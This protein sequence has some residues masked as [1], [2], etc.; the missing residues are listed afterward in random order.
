[1]FGRR[2]KKREST[3]LLAPALLISTWIK[4]YMKAYINHQ[5][6]P[7]QKIMIEVIMTIEDGR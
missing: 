5:L 1:M 2:D 3:A 4:M 7:Q 6:G